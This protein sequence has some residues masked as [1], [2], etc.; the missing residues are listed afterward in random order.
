V[1]L[2]ALIP[3]AGCMPQRIGGATPADQVIDKLRDDNQDLKTMVA[4]RDRTLDLQRRQIEALG[5]QLAATRPAL[6]GVNPADVPRLVEVR[7][8]NYS[9]VV[10]GPGGPGRPA[11]PGGAVL[12]LYVQPLDQRGRFITVLAEA[13]VQAVWIQPG[14]APTV[15]AGHTYQ[16]AEFDRAY[17]DGFTGTHYTLELP[18]KEVPAGAKEAV[19]KLELTDAATGVTV[20]CAQTLALAAAPATLPAPPR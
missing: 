11:V 13:K 5:Q 10:M 9:G 2:L 19:V 6:A 12:R 8:D 4:D 18:L 1:V 14:A 15:L 17:R 16:A 20:S 3:A 7:L